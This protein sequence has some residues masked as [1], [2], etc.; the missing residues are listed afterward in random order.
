MEPFRGSLAHYRLQLLVPALFEGQLV[1][2]TMS[3]ERGAVRR[4]FHLWHGRIVFSSSTAPE[5]HLAQ[6]LVDLNILDA[7]TA[8]HAFEGAEAQRIWLGAYLMEQGLVDASRLREA[9]AFK[10]RESLFDCY[11]WESGEVCITPGNPVNRGGMELDLP[12]QTLHKEALARLREWRAFRHQFPDPRATFQVLREA[13]PAPSEEDEMLLSRAERGL[14]ISA[15]IFQGKDRPLQL[16]RRILHLYRRGAIVASSA[17]NT[18]AQRWSDVSELVS[19]SRHHLEQG[20]FELAAE[21]SAQALEHASVPEAQALFRDAEMRLADSLQAEVQALEG[22]LVFHP[23]PAELAPELTSDDLYLYS[24]LRSASSVVET[25]KA[26]PMGALA[27]YRSIR[28]LLDGGLVTVSGPPHTLTLRGA[29][30][31][32]WRLRHD[33]EVL[34]DGADRTQPGSEHG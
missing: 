23:I 24:K 32:G 33:P 16:A 29:V 7:S 11:E 2:G 31:T 27:S 17:Q 14:S 18:D 34:G 19:L 21:L 12:L 1:S 5:E 30:R 22:R 10:A 3:L 9:L 4:E 26:S 28:R 15:L 6:V 8:A 20:Q 25:L 13:A